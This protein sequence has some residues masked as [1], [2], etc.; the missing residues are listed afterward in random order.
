MKTD[1]SGNNK[2][3]LIVDDSI[4]NRILLRRVLSN[5]GYE[6]REAVDGEE[7]V[8]LSHEFSP[9]VIIMDVIMPRMDG[10]HACQKLKTDPVLADV[11]VLFVTSLDDE[12]SVVKAFEAGGVDF[13]TKPFRENEIL[14]RVSVHSELYVSRLKL[15]SYA[16]R[17]KQQLEKTAADEEAGRR[18]Q[19][20]LLPPD[21][22]R[23]RDFEF[24]RLLMPS[25]SM[26]GDFVDYFA[27]DDDRVA[28]YML[29]VA[30]HGVASAFVSVLVKS[31]VS[32]A[33]GD[34]KLGRDRLINSPADL[35]HELNDQ[36]LHESLEKHVTMFFGII[37]TRRGELLYANGGQFPFPLLCGDGSA[38]VIQCKSMPV[39]LFDFT[40]YTNT[41]IALPAGS[42]LVLLSD[43]IL[44]I[45]PESNLL[46]KLAQLDHV[47]SAPDATLEQIKSGLKLDQ[48]DELPDDVAMLSIKRDAH[49]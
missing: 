2:R 23:M 25:L 6:V 19:F 28:F 47:C 31:F 29:D 40:H 39:G 32:H 13:V 45:L 11:P 16:H 17:I 5:K 8:N 26:S 4:I 44:E 48:K 18:V 3:V 42:R 33:M 9:H 34:Y 35:L 21:G 37:D 38:Q 1:L 30:G 27:L 22:F 43:G 36:L 24:H 12:D 46:D 14:A 15:Q 20:R 7:A 41:M 49:G 10:F